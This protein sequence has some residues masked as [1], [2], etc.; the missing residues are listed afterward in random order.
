MLLDGDFTE[1]ALRDLAARSP[2]TMV[3]MATHGH[4]AGVANASYVLTG[5]GRLSFDAL[6]DLVREAGNGGALLELLVLS[7]CETAIGDERSVLG[8][9]GAAYRSGA[10]TVVG[11]LWSVDDASTAAL[12]SAFYEHLGAGR[13]GKSDALSAAQRELLADER[14][15]HPYYWSPFVL[16]GNWL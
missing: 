4:F 10:K 11:S 8:L 12:Q 3:H 5:E 16:V 14:F 13:L 6:S 7:A 2:V 15:A 9:A 1:D